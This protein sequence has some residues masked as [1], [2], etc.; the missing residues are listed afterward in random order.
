MKASFCMPLDNKKG[1]Y[2]EKDK[3]LSREV[4]GAQLYQSELL[5]FT[6][7]AFGQKQQPREGVEPST[8]GLR[9]QCSATELTRPQE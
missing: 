3:K 4:N 7:D 6:H 8:P 2:F 9:D 1:E 5:T